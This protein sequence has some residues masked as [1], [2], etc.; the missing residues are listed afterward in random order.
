MLFKDKFIN[1]TSHEIYP[2]IIYN[3]SDNDIVY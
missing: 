3:N 1:C 2:A